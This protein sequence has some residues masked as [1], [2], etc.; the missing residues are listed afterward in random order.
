[1][2]QGPG[3]PEVTVLRVTGTLTSPGLVPAVP[4]TQRQCQQRPKNQPHLPDEKT[5][6]K[7][8]VQ[9]RVAPGWRVGV[10][11][12]RSREACLQLAA[13]AHSQGALSVA[14]Q[15]TAALISPRP[16]QLPFPGGQMSS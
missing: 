13:G 4:L 7:E 1:M 9:G 3:P 2:W 11:M 12:R 15:A 8:D 16:P 10:S 14:L 6:L 5:G